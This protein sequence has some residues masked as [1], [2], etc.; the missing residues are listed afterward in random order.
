[1]GELEKTL[2]VGNHSEVRQKIIKGVENMCDWTMSGRWKKSFRKEA[3]KIC[4]CFW[5]EQ[6]ASPQFSFNEYNKGIADAL[7]DLADDR[8]DIVVVQKN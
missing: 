4:G 2:A 5:E 7:N 3:F 6:K 1:M 8:K